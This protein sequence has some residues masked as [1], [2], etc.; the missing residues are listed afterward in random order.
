MSGALEITAESKGIVS[1]P[2]TRF[3]KN[4][5]FQITAQS[6]VHILLFVDT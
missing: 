1:R 6:I 3:V 4:L 5:T 2:P